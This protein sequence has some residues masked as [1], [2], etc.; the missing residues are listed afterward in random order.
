[1]GLDLPDRS[2]DEW[3][4]WWEACID[5]YFALDMLLMFRTATWTRIGEREVNG[6]VLARNYLKGWF[7]A[8]ATSAIN[9]RPSIASPWPGRTRPTR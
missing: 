1:M 4:F 6:K 3:L 7:G 2:T 9:N 5:L 8:W